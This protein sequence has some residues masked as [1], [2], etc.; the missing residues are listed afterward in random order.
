[1]SLAED[2]TNAGLSSQKVTPASIDTPSD[3]GT[4]VDSFSELITVF[5]EAI[6]TDHKCDSCDMPV[7]NM[8]KHTNINRCRSLPFPYTN[9]IAKTTIEQERIWATIEDKPWDEPAPSR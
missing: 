1:M 4:T 7:K 8:D 2:N 5:D 6:K 3:T 9:K